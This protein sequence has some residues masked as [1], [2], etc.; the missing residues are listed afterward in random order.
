MEPGSSAGAQ[1]PPPP[2]QDEF[3]TGALVAVVDELDHAHEAAAAAAS[4]SASAPYVIEAGEV[5]AQRARREDHQGLV[6]KVYLALGSLVSDQQGL[7]DRYLEEARLGH[8]MVVASAADDEQADRVWDVLKAK[9]AHD[10]TWVDRWSIRD[11][12]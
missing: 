1:P 7:E 11:M 8:H 12:R 9:G 5:Q 3:P 10:G 4:V 2:A 6:A